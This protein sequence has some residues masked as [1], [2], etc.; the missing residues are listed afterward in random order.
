MGWENFLHV[1]SKFR[2]INQR[3]KLWSHTKFIYTHRD[4]VPCTR[5][6]AETAR[7][8]IRTFAI[9]SHPFPALHN[10]RRCGSCGV[11]HSKK[12]AESK[13]ANTS[14]FIVPRTTCVSGPTP[15]YLFVSDVPTS[16]PPLSCS[17]WVIF[18]ASFSSG[19]NFSFRELIFESFQLSQ[20]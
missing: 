9:L 16:L 4:S 8:I 5:C 10:K 20:H 13:E 14:L 11:S 6:T 2:A 3:R 19:G 17:G 1:K 12:D 7:N 18:C 15:H